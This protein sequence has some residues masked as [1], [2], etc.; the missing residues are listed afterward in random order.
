MVI[1]TLFIHSYYKFYLINQIA[2]IA[3]AT[4]RR[5]QRVI[6][7]A[8]QSSDRY[9]TPGITDVSASYYAATC[10]FRA[11]SSSSSSINQYSSCLM[12]LSN[13]MRAQ[14]KNQTTLAWEL[15]ILLLSEREETFAIAF[16]NF[17]CAI[18]R[19]QRVDDVDKKLHF[20][21]RYL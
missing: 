11:L 6:D 4:Q 7:E 15:E 3:I 8:K 16:L 9:D 13:A 18:F 1:D 10:A 5:I 19:L 12:S 17:V 14:T 20:R 2:T 21:F